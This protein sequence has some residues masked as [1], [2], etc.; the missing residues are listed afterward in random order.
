MNNAALHF[1]LFN[2]STLSYVIFNI[3]AV[4]YNNCIL[5]QFSDYAGFQIAAC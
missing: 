1:N 5:M 2:P 4:H 3:L